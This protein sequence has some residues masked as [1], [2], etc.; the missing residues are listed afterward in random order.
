MHAARSSSGWPPTR[1]SSCSRSCSAPCCSARPRSRA[2]G[3]AWWRPRSSWAPRSR[4]LASTMGVAMKID[5]FTK[6]IF[7]YLF[8]Y[9]VGLRVGPSFLNSLKGDG[10]KFAMLAVVCSVL[11]AARA[12]C[13]SRGCWDLPAGAAGG[14]LAGSMTMSAS[15][16]SAEEAVRQG[17]FP[18][19]A[20]RDVR[21]RE[22]HDRALVRPHL[23][24]G[25][26]RHHPDL[27]VPAALVGR[28]REGRGEEV[29][30]G[31]RRPERRRRRR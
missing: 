1:T 12:R 18:L 17:A 3:S 27:Q 19:P 4:R 24:L 20:G 11:G 9:G 7:Y 6:S 29:R 16:G 25:H 21:G 5:D 26:G 30:A 14:I 8:M 31:V 15:I 22:R 10:L 23:H 2:T 13:S 28:R